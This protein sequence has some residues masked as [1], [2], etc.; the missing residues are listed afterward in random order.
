MSKL[1]LLTLC[2]ELVATQVR[3][4]YLKIDQ[5]KR[6]L[7]VSSFLG[8]RNSHSDSRNCIA[9]GPSGCGRH[10]PFLRSCPPSSAIHFWVRRTGSSEEASSFLGKPRHLK[11]DSAKS[12]ERHQ[13]VEVG[14]TGGHL[15]G[16]HPYGIPYVTQAL[17][18]QVVR[19]VFRIDRLQKII[20]I[21]G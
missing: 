21:S 3:A 7:L 10:P 9:P 5:S 12:R 17:F 8:K 16:E 19:L 6:W 20:H 15:D 18:P 14:S 13:S 1:I 2:S 4:T 11:N